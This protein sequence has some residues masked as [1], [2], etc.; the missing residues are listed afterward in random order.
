MGKGCETILQ[1]DGSNFVEW[2]HDIHDYLATKKLAAYLEDSAPIGRDAAVA[3]DEDKQA[4]GFLRM[5][6]DASIKQQIYNMRTTNAAI[7]FLQR[8]FRH[9]SEVK[10]TMLEREKQLQKRD[11]ETIAQYFQRARRLRFD[12]IA[13]GGRW[14]ESEM[15]IPI[16]TGLPPEYDM[17]VEIAAHMNDRSLSA[18]ERMLL[19]KE[20]MLKAQAKSSGLVGAIANRG[21]VRGSSAASGV[22]NEAG[23]YGGY[24]G[25]HYCD[26]T[27]HFARNCPIR[28]ADKDVG[29]YWSNIHFPPR[30]TGSSGVG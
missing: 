28:I 12:I 5:S 2:Y 16:L 8:Q 4:L 3:L 30:I 29:I 21:I 23:A 26:I 15:R 24:G 20:Q 11:D 7:I 13:A 14:D 10:L 9:P 17:S 6:C 18:L 19:E 27:G 25:C 1:S 22:S